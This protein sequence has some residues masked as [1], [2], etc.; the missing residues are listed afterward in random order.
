MR[1]YFCC[2]FKATSE[3]TREFVVGVN[4]SYSQ[5]CFLT[6]F[7]FSEMKLR[8]GL[9]NPKSAIKKIREVGGWGG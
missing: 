6:S 7:C 2:I 1:R 4:K 9:E 8:P 3:Y 5:L